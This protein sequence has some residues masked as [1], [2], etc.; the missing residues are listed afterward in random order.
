MAKYK[1]KIY[2]LKNNANGKIYVGNTGNFKERSYAHLY[3]L[4]KN[5]HVNKTL[6]EDFNLYGEG[7][8]EFLIAEEVDSW[9]S[10]RKEHEWMISLKTYNSD[11][12]YNDRDP[13]FYS[14][15]YGMPTKNLIELS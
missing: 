1:S 8:F 13:F 12:G 5:N 11:Y 14:K 4:R 3:H 2:L 15:Q 6:Q 9:L 10:F 7:A